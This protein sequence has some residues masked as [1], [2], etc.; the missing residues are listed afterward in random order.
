MFR[1]GARKK[2]RRWQYIVSVVPKSSDKPETGN[3]GKKKKLF[4]IGA[5]KKNRR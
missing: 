3:D 2:N 5:I 1:I 4:R